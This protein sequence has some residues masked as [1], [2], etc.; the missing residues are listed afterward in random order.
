VSARY[1]FSLVTSVFSLFNVFFT[2]KVFIMGAT[3][4]KADKEKKQLLSYLSGEATMSI[5]LNRKTC[6]ENEEVQEAGAVWL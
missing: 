5:Y 4:K 6:V 2:E 1:F 3:Y